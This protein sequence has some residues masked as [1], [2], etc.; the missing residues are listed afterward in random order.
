M[1]ALKTLVVKRRES[2]KS[3]SWMDTYRVVSEDLGLTAYEVR[4]DLNGI[5]SR[6]EEKLRDIEAGRAMNVERLL[7][8]FH[9]TLTGFETKL[10]TFEEEARGESFVE[11]LL[12]RDLLTQKSP[13][14]PSTPSPLH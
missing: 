9:K 11:F 14:L 5:L 3:A 8:D 4:T 12:D 13:D 7:M 1:T 10:E 2:R 6:L